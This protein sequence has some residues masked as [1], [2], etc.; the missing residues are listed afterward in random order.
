MG[1][2]EVTGVAM[3]DTDVVGYAADITSTPSDDAV[4]ADATQP[5]TQTAGE[6]Q[7]A[8]T[9]RPETS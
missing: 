7:A 2:A 9:S 5:A 8:E 3:T 6:S 1:H 4:G